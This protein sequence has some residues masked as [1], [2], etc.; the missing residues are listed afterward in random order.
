MRVSYIDEKSITNTN[1][2]RN[3]FY[4]A[5]KKANDIEEQIQNL[6]PN[7]K[8]YGT[9][10]EIAKYT[11]SKMKS[12]AVVYMKDPEDTDYIWKLYD[13]VYLILE[14]RLRTHKK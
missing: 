4:D 14:K 8:D 2:S 7:E 6:L 1:I 13:T 11:I 3:I 9:I 10:I 12:V 5:V